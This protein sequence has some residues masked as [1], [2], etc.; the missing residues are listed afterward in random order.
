MSETD[1][2]VTEYTYPLIQR[3]GSFNFFGK[4][5]AHRAIVAL[6]EAI[7]RAFDGV[8]WEYTTS[9]DGLRVINA[10]SSSGQ[11]RGAVGY[12]FRPDGANHGLSGFDSVGSRLSFHSPEKD[13]DSYRKLEGIVK[14]HIRGAYFLVFSRA[15]LAGLGVIE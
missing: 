5:K 14:E 1:E 2:I 13:D 10:Y 4:K 7:S 8:N 15:S 9:S 11:V 3:G 12:V 6:T